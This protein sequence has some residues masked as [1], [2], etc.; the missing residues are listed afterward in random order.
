MP[1]T[2]IEIIATVGGGSLVIALLST[3]NRKA[4]DLLLEL[5]GHPRPGR[6]D[7]SQSG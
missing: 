1:R 5:L 3:F 4:R 6:A 7:T 2:T